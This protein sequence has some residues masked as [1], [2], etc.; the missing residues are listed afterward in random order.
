MDFTVQGYISNGN[1]GSTFFMN[2][3]ASIRKQKLNERDLLSNE[4]QE[5]LKTK[6]TSSFTN[7]TNSFEMHRVGLYFPIQNEAPIQGILNYLEA[8]RIKCYFP[9]VSKDIN[10]RV[11]KFSEYKKEKKL[12]NNR[13]GIPEPLNSDFI[14]LSLIDLFLLP[15]VAFDNKGYRIGRGKGYYDTTFNGIK[16]I[17]T[18]KI[19]GVAY[20][21]QEEETCYPEAH[22]FK[23]DAVLCPNGLRE[24]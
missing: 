15:L 21:F 9:I 18:I 17:K 1:L 24:F 14:D 5:L 13:F 11:M 16:S 19:W 4:D 12:R 22:D 7:S 23:L 2:N 10:K 6:L 8:H 20:E 3:K